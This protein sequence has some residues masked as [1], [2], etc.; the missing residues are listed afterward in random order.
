MMSFEIEM[1]KGYT[2]L[3]MISLAHN[4]AITEYASMIVSA[5]PVNRKEQRGKYI[6]EFR[7]IH[8]ETNAKVIDTMEQMSKR[9]ESQKARS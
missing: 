2:E 4:A 3:L 9:V 7:R 6:K 5:G 1:Q 8:D